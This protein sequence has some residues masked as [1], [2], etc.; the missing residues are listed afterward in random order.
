MK[1]D[2]CKKEATINLQRNWQLFKL[3]NK[4]GWQEYKTWE[5]DTNEFY[6]EKCAEEEGII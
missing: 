2:N 5:G 6:C 1:C 3:D 4:G